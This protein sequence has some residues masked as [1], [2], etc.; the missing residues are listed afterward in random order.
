MVNFKDKERKDW[1]NFNLVIFKG[2][3]EEYVGLKTFLQKN[4]GIKEVV[5][6]Y[7]NEGSGEYLLELKK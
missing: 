5:E 7:K 3:K 1:E 4:S 6:L 2:R